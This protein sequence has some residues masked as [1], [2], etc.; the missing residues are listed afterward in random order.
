MKLAAAALAL[1]FTTATPALA[2]AQLGRDVAPIAYDITINPN[3]QA[4]TFSGSETITVN[5]RKATR[6]ILA[7]ASPG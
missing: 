5:V 1:M 3:A 6:T 2:A 7:H 4:M